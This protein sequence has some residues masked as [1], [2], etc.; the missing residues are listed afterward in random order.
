MAINKDKNVL[1]NI[2]I[3]KA[4]NEKLNII[5]ADLS[6]DLGINLTKSQAIGILIKNYKKESPKAT[7]KP[8][9]KAYSDNYNYQSQIQA[10][11]LKLNVSYP[12]LAEII[13]IPLSTLKKYA[14][15]QQQPKDENAK[16]IKQAIARC[17]IK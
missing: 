3:S 12:H 6:Q 9:K 11:K 13:G 17:G 4:D 1:F 2:T 5:V 8:Q 10:L 14:Y 16:L 7:T 15:G